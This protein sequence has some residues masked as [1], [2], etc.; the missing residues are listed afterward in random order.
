MLNAAIEAAVNSGL[1]RAAVVARVMPTFN[2]YSKYGTM[3]SE[4]LYKLDQ[5]LDKIFGRE[6]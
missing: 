2:K 4:P 5:V 3:D 6:K 1:D